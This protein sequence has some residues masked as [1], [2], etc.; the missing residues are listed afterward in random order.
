MASA[1]PPEAVTA[2][3][4][5]GL[6]FLDA[7]EQI[8]RQSGGTAPLHYAEITQ[9]AIGQGLIESNGLTPDATM[10]GAVQREIEEATR[11]GRTP[12]FIRHRNGLI[13]LMIWLPKGIEQLVQTHNDQV[14][15]S[16]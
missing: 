14:R 13:G 12:R 2:S 15:K 6:T 7:A 3:M 8:L 11:R 1:Q 5:P 10:R 16:L 9:R 4:N